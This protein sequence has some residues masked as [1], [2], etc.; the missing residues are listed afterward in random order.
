MWAVNHLAYFQLTSLLL[1]RIRDSAPA[2]IVS[3]ASE[4][5]RFVSSLDPQDPAPA[6]ERFRWWR[7][8]GRSKLGNL[9]FTAE[10]ARRL[11]SSGVTANAVH[12]GAVATRLG[13][14][15]GWW[16][17]LLT[18]PLG[19]FFRTAE[20]G[21]ETSLY[22]AAAPELSGV[23]GRY[24]SNCREKQPSALARDPDLASRLWT[25]SARQVGTNDS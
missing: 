23:T 19:L 12:P 10:L 14:Q 8:Y 21:A 16:A 18:K 15:N 25:S 4:A 3:V 2:R 7:G 13:T 9:L 17:P 22:V 20:R 5:H 11:E 24:F 6:Q 1:D